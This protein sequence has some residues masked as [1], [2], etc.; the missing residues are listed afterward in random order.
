MTTPG[1]KF[2]TW[3]EEDFTEPAAVPVHVRQEMRF[4]WLHGAKVE[5]L[6]KT[7]KMPADWVDEFVRVEHTSKPH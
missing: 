1:S 3:V 6:A 4:L 7:F 5:Q 2:F